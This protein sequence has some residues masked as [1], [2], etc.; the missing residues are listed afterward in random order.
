L[1]FLSPKLRDAGR[2]EG[3]G[4]LRLLSVAAMALTGAS[5]FGLYQIKYDTRQ[6]EAKLQAGERS[7]E[8]MEGDIAVLKAEK[9]YLARPERSEALAKKQGLG[10]IAGTQYVL[11]AELESQLKAG[12]QD[13]SVAKAGKA[14]LSQPDRIEA[15]LRQQD[16]LAGETR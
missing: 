8:K 3:I 10:P 7:I 6:L 4:M 15:L 14:T 2:D 16:L 11:P 12:G 9:A 13:T 1:A 5:A